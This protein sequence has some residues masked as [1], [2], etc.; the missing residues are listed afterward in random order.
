MKENIKIDKDFKLTSWAVNNTTTVLFITFLIVL[1]GVSTYIS[2]PKENF[3][4]IS[5]PKIYIGTTHPG[6]SPQDIENLITRPLEKELNTISSV[7]NITSTSIQDHST[8]VVEF[9]T[10]TDVSEALTK[11]K[12]AVDKAKADLPSDLDQD[13]NIFEMDMSEFPILN[14]NLSG[15]YSLDQLKEYAE[16]LKYEVEKFHELSNAEIHGLDE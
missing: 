3:P 1:M 9:T 14:I 4:E 7:D 6:N 8:I 16:Y 5:I 10:A 11:V 15:N 12:D 13:P 2:L